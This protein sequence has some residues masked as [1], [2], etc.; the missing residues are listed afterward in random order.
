MIRAYTV[1]MPVQTPPNLIARWRCTVMAA[2][3]VAAGAALAAPAFRGDQNLPGLG[4][5]LRPLA[6]GTAEPLPQ[7]KAYT[8]T[9][10]R[11]GHEEQRVLHDPHELWYATQH[12]AQW[13]DAHGNM[14]VIGHVKRRPPR[15]ESELPHVPHEV[16]ESAMEA[17]EARLDPDN[18]EHLARWVAAFGGFSPSTPENL[19]TGNNLVQARFYPTG[20]RDTL[21][22]LFRVRPRSLAAQAA[23]VPWFCAIVRIGDNTP[24]AKVR[25]AFETQFL[26]TVAA[27]PSASQ[28]GERE[29][30][31]RT[32][33]TR[34]AGAPRSSPA[35]EAARKSIANL[36]DWWVAE[37]PEYVI[38]SDIRSSTGRALIRELQETLPVLRAA[39]AQLVPPDRDAEE[40]GVVRIFEDPEAYRSYVGPAH[41]W[42][43]GIW[44]PQ[45]RELV[46]QAQERARDV[47]MEIIRHEGFHQYL[48]QAMPGVEHAVWFNE[49]HACF[50]ESAR[51]GG[52]RRVTFPENQRVDELLKHLPEVA[53]R[54]PAI[55]RADTAAF[56][57]GDDRVRSLNYTTA[58]GLVYFL[59]KGAPSR[60]MRDYEQIPDAYLKHL[61]DGKD[62]AAATAAAFAG[63]DM[64]RFQQDF[65]EFWRRHRGAARQYDPLRGR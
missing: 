35:R 33:P 50:V 46:I 39:Y 42:S 51:I 1:S 2:L 65:A 56:Y 43:S 28:S 53:A 37:T 25:Q 12:G 5:R 60:R 13:R 8:Y 16:F 38:L 4:L 34:G 19:R 54:I 49:G 36:K 18:N 62:A 15:I 40:F 52:G 20:R 3:L 9:F 14:L 47:T 57:A 24:P 10:R 6:G 31:S 45:R 48:H 61:A 21:A 63:I 11:N 41:A 30:R 27:L 59:R 22:Y 55:L 29:L 64:E 32:L 7:P 44:D 23:S 26:P 58:W 17:G